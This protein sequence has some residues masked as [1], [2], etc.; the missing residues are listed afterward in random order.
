MQKEFPG[1]E[2]MSRQYCS[3]QFSVPTEHIQVSEMF[4]KMSKISEYVS[5]EDFNLVQSS[6]DQ[7][8]CYAT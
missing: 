1:A 6:L 5:I 7:V 8:N 4:R 3:S 2:L